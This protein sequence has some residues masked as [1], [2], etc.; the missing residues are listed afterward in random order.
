MGTYMEWDRQRSSFAG[1]VDYISAHR[2]SGIGGNSDWFLAE[3]VE[4]ERMLQDYAG[5]LT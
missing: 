5:L 4:I 3:G 1:T 2:Y